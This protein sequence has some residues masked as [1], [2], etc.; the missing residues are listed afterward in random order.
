MCSPDQPKSEEEERLRSQVRKFTKDE[1]SGLMQEYTYDIAAIGVEMR[2]LGAQ[3]TRAKRKIKLL[4]KKLS[5][6]RRGVSRACIKDDFVRYNLCRVVTERWYPPEPIDTHWAL[7]NRN[8]MVAKKFFF[9]LKG[10]DD[11]IFQAKQVHSETIWRKSRY[12]IC[13]STLK[14]LVA[15]LQAGFIYQHY[16]AWFKSRKRV[17]SPVYNHLQHAYIVRN[18]HD[19]P[20]EQFPDFIDFENGA[21]VWSGT[22]QQA[23]VCEGSGSV[24]AGP[25]AGTDGGSER[26]VLER[27]GG[28]ISAM[29][30]EREGEG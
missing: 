2:K 8:M 4:K 17:V 1:V 6:A 27:P 11:Q 23:T 22:R 30:E 29:E 20:L 12:V 5:F 19:I 25:G 24:Q 28:D 13:T 26:H 9:C 18:L 10:T 14:T 15:L 3:K 16:H 21:K 7:V